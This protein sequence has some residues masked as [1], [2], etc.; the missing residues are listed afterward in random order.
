MRKNGIR[1][2]SAKFFALSFFLKSTYKDIFRLLKIKDKKSC[3][4]RNYFNK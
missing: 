2:E 1:D 3:P 4:Y